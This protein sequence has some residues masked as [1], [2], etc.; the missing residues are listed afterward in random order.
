MKIDDHLQGNLHEL[1]KLLD[2][3]LVDISGEEREESELISDLEAMEHSKRMRRVK[4]LEDCLAYVETKYEYAHGLLHHLH[5]VLKTQMH[6]AMKL[7]PWAKKPDQLLSHLKL[8][9][10]LELNVVEKINNFEN[11]TGEKFHDLFLALIK[12]EHII[13]TMDSREKRMH[14]IM[15]KR[16]SKVFSNEITEGITCEWA[17]T[18][19]NQVQDIVTNHMTLLAK[20]YNPHDAVDFEF[21]NRPGF[22]N[23]VRESIQNIRKNNVS[24][25][26]INVFVHLFREWYN[27]E[28]D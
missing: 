28:R 22:I 23:L 24:E 16:F 4:R 25:Q 14:A 19:Y 17:S 13:K 21:V 10:E 27:H 8:Q 3:E 2:L 5:S 6:I 1:K 15:Q 12:G 20:G 9:L 18:V 7:E 11:A 26:M